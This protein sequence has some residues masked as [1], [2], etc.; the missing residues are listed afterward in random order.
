MIRRYIDREKLVVNLGC[1]NVPVYWSV[2]S[3]ISDWMG[4]GK[5]GGYW[6]IVI[7]SSCEYHFIRVHENLVQHPSNNMSIYPVGCTSMI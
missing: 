3:S 7:L 1:H 5:R 6:G 2:R 4:W